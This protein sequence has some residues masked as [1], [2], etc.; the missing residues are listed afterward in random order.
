MSK[1]LATCKIVQFAL[2]PTVMC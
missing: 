1:T 2:P